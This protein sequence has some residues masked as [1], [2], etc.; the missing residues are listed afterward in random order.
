MVDSDS[1]KAASNK[2]YYKKRNDRLTFM[3]MGGPGSP[4]K[5]F[6]VSARLFTF[7]VTFFCIALITVGA[8]AY[9]VLQDYSDNRAALAA[10]SE[11]NDSLT[12]TTRSQAAMISELQHFAG[13]MLTKIEEIESLNSEVRTKVGLEESDDGEAQIVAGYMVSR[14]DS[15][16]SQMNMV[17]DEE[18][19]SLEDLL[20]ELLSMDLVMTEQIMELIYLK[21]DVDKQLTFESSLPS[22]WPMEGRFTSAYGN[23][24]NPFGKGT[25][26]HQGI[27]IANKTGTKIHAAGDGVVTFAGTKSGWGRMVLINHGYGYVSLYAHCSSISVKEGQMVE[28]G[29][30]IAACGSTGRT[31]GPHLHFGVQLSGAFIDPM[32]VLITGGA[33]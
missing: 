7:C 33:D 15:V 31:T 19:D 11:E 1:R 22:L 4:I 16:L 27:D 10:L 21:D 30:A 20:Q 28:R 32:K 2:K 3:V 23:R 17:V 5:D 6:Q 25:E 24:K 14:G 18:L 12:G 13:N 26:F 9:Y 8:V 29:E